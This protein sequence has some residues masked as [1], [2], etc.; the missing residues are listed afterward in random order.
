MYVQ[1]DPNKKQDPTDHTIMNACRPPDWKWR[2]AEGAAAGTEPGP[3]RKWDT[4]DGAAAIRRAL[5]FMSRYQAVNSVEDKYELAFSMP[6]MYWAYRMYEDL[7][8][9]IRYGVEAHILA[10]STD[11]DIAMR[12]CYSPQVIRT[13]EDMF[14][15]VRSR[16]SC[17]QWVVHSIIGVSVHHGVAERQFDLLWKLY[18]LM[19]G[20]HVLDALELKFISPSRPRS[21]EAVGAA[22][23]DD[24]VATMKLK[25]SL[26]AKGVSANSSTFGM[27]LDRFTRFVEIERNSDTQGQAHSSILQGVEEMLAMMPF[28]VGHDEKVR[29]RVKVSKNVAELT[30]FESTAVELTY[31]ET[32]QS[33]AGQPLYNPDGL[34]M[35]QFPNSVRKE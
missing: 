18:G 5:K 27:L 30:E 32:L 34:R 4:K 17:R 14:F 12:V 21:A 2:R 10:K 16:L 20:Q 15:D 9:V 26:S 1:A 6:E 8:S 23:E 22:I 25:A 28:R 7:S 3:S 24:A 19:M 13:F 11:V 35:M 33:A 31:A 29:G